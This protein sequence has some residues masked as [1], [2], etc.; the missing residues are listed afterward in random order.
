MS[1]PKKAWIWGFLVVQGV[2]DLALLVIWVATEAGVHSLA[3]EFP[4]VV[5]VAKKKKKKKERKKEKR[6]K[7]GRKPTLRSLGF[8]I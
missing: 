4:H 3:Q 5:G 6:K 1:Y 8:S 7:E 2:K